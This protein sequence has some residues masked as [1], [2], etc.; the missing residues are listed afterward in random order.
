MRRYGIQ[1]EPRRAWLAVWTRTQHLHDTQPGFAAVVERH[2]TAT[3]VR[4]TQ[5]LDAVLTFTISLEA[6]LA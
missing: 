5:D 6:E 3:Q 4:T 2:L 1:P